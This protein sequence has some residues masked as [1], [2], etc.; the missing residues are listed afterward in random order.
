MNKK[1]TTFTLSKAETY[2]INPFVEKAI[3]EI[4]DNTKRRIKWLKGNKAIQHHYDNEKGETI[5]TAAFI[6]QIE[7]DETQFTKFYVSQLGLLFDL[8]K[9][10]LRVFAYILNTLQPKSDRFYIH[11]KEALKYTEYKEEKSIFIGLAFL[12]EKSFIARSESHYMYYINPMVFFNG[13]R[14][15]FAKT[16]I[17]KR[18]KLLKNDPNQGILNFAIETDD[19]DV[20][21][22]KTGEI[23]PKIKNIEI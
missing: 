3:E 8:P 4:Q 10:A 19:G 23:M 16:Y 22:T 7:I 15:T 1:A 17:K 11:M 5:A 18:D 6:Q 13:D 9:P 20:V 12:C 2:S 21:N 14:I